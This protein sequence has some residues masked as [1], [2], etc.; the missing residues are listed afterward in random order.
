MSKLYIRNADDTDWIEFVSTDEMSI[1][2]LNDVTGTPQNKQALVYNS[3]SQKY[4]PT[5]VLQF[6]GLA[7]ISVSAS[8]PTNPTTGDLWI[9][10]S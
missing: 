9:D 8:Q 2:I 1:S 10:I 4:E 3:T 6:A 5:N 7:K